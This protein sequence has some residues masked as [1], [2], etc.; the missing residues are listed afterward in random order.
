LRE[1]SA[2]RAFAEAATSGSTDAAERAAA[3]LGR[4]D[5]LGSTR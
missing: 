2:A 3:V 4:N 5:R 1:S